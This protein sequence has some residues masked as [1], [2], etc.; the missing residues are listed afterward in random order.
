M[1]QNKMKLTVLIGSPVETYTKSIGFFD[2]L[3]KRFGCNI[4]KLDNFK[5]YSKIKNNDV[6]F[7]FCYKPQRDDSYLSSYNY[8]K[9]QKGIELPPP[10]KEIINEIDADK[11]LTLGFCGVFDGK[12]ND[13]YLPISVSS[14]DFGD[15]WLNYKKIINIKS[16]NKLNF[17][18]FLVDKIIGKKS[19]H[20]TTNKGLMP[21]HFQNPRELSKAANILKKR[22]NSVDMELYPIIEYFKEKIPIGSFFVSSDILNKEE[23]QMRGSLNLNYKTYLNKCFNSL[24]IMLK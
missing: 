22:F 9:T 13:I 4:K 23:E 6:T 24:E 8:W 19:D 17:N 18:N 21:N 15:G 16:E 1:F 5:F 11:I 14:K 10:V 3:K 12:R 20:L 7:L 2:N